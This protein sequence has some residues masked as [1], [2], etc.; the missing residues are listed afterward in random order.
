VQEKLAREWLWELQGLLAVSVLI[1]GDRQEAA[2]RL[3]SDLR[4]TYKYLHDVSAKQQL[5]HSLQ[6]P[7]LTFCVLRLVM[8]VGLWLYYYF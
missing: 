8:E 3:A 2:K 6:C 5:L 7:L 1:S 4:R